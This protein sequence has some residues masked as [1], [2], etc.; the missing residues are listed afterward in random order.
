MLRF[1][2]SSVGIILPADCDSQVYELLEDIL[3][4][5][6]REEVPL[7]PKAA[8]ARRAAG[9]SGSISH[10]IV[11]GMFRHIQGNSEGNF[12]EVIVLINLS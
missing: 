3:H 1:L 10:G 5:V 6:I 8:R 2:G 9:I 12:C 4:G 7:Q 11:T